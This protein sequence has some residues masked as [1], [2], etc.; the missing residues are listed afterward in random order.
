MQGTKD[1]RLIAADKYKFASDI[2]I[3]TTYF[4]PSHYSTK[5]ENYKQFRDPIDASGIPLFTIECEFGDSDFE[6]NEF[7]NVRQ[8]RC[9]DIMWQKERL[10]NEAVRTLPSKFEKVVWLDCDLLF[11]N[12]SWALELSA[13]LDTQVVVQPFSSAIRLPRGE[14]CFTGTGPRWNS[15]GLVYNDSAVQSREGWDAHGH[16]GFAWAAKREFFRECGLYDACI[17]G[18]G[19]H[20]IAHAIAG[21]PECSCITKRLI[22]TA[23]QF[24]HF[25][26]WA[27]LAYSIVD[28]KIG[29]ISGEVLHLWHGDYENRRYLERQ[30][31]VNRLGYDPYSDIRVSD[32][33]CWEWCSDKPELHA[34][35][36]EYFNGRKEDG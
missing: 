36:I 35:A 10:I 26:D 29:V 7:K 9:N 33:G 19:D 17:L 13:A 30:D 4:N 2:A 8:I 12:S 22:R 11:V 34:W 24:S 21:E 23:S 27:K 3:V 6:L 32:S 15:F 16:T 18:N 28:G 14:T 20:Y 1:E 25:R 5:L 31:E